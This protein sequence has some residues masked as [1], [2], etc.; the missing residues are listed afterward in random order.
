VLDE[1]NQI[2]FPALLNEKSSLW[3]KSFR[4]V[5]KDVFIS[6]AASDG[7]PSETIKILPDFEVYTRDGVLIS[8]AAQFVADIL[9]APELGRRFLADAVENHRW[10]TVR[11]EPPLDRN[12][13]PIFLK[14]LNPE[15]LRQI[16]SVEIRGECQIFIHQFGVQRNRLGEIS[17]EWGKTQISGQLAMIVATQDE[18]NTSKVSVSMAATEGVINL[19]K[20]PKDEVVERSGDHANLDE[21]GPARSVDEGDVKPGGGE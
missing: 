7:L 6:V 18:A 12:G 19:F 17:F 9:R 10:F 15:V 20:P 5:S 8:T 1:I 2:D 13:E 16:T 14:K 21:G 11:G 4:A 3:T